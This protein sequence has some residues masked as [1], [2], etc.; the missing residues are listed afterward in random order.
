[1]IPPFF[2]A[3]KTESSYS[4]ARHIGISHNTLVV[5]PKRALFY[6]NSFLCL[7]PLLKVLLNN[8][9]NLPSWNRLIPKLSLENVKIFNPQIT[10]LLNLAKLLCLYRVIMYEA[11]TS[12]DTA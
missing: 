8:V 2:L 10:V 11:I 5:S 4:E 3:I 12:I 1:M 9:I 7:Y 6:I